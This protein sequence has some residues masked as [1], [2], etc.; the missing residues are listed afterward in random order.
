MDETKLKKICEGA[1]DISYSGVTIKEFHVLP[2]Q[3]WDEEKENW[4]PHSYSIFIVLKK[5][6]PYD[7]DY[8]GVDRFLETLLGFECC[9]DLV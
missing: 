8:T 9:V 3:R 1:L 5:S 7:S 6:L 2:T 4:V